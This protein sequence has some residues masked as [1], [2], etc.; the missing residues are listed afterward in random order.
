M[1]RR[2]WQFWVLLILIVCSYPCGD[3]HPHVHWERVSW[4]PFQGVG[5]SVNLSL[6]VVR[7]VVL[8]VPF[9][10]FYVQWQSNPRTNVVF[11]T[12]LLAAL[13]STGCEFFQIFCHSRTPSMTDVS[14]NVMGGA[15]GAVIAV[16]LAFREKQLLT[17]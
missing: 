7:N 4:I 1:W 3:F 5:H 9:G 11:K 17:R 14:T 13:L 6:D 8:Y 10:F 12:T 15:I 16:T 2:L